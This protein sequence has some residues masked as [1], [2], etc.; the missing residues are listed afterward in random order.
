ML[1]A[2]PLVQK[3][4]LVGWD[5]FEAGH[6]MEYAAYAQTAP[7][8]IGEGWLE[9]EGMEITVSRNNMHDGR[10]QGERR[11]VTPRHPI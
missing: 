9:K 11:I 5:M 4:N 7:N 8:T 3:C 2:P 1:P 6:G 10:K